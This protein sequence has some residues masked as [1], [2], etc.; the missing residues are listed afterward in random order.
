MRRVSLDFTGPL[1]PAHKIQLLLHR[2]TVANST[3]LYCT[4]VVGVIVM[5][6]NNDGQQLPSDPTAPRNPTVDPPTPAPCANVCSSSRQAHQP[7]QPQDSRSQR[8]WMTTK[9]WPPIVAAFPP[10]LSFPASGSSLPD[11]PIHR[12]RSS[13]SLPRTSESPSHDMTNR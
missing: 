13:I 2:A 9:P 3:V 6:D 5:T 4:D 7:L 10:S 8:R 12:F 11:C 1:L